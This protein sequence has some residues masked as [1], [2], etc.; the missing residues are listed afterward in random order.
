MT[1]SSFSQRQPPALLR[2]LSHKWTAAA[3]GHCPLTYS[4][5]QDLRSNLKAICPKDFLSSCTFSG[6][7]RRANDLFNVNLFYNDLF[8]RLVSTMT[9]TKIPQ[10]QQPTLLRRSFPPRTPVPR[11]NALFTCPHAAIPTTAPPPREGGEGFSQ[12]AP[13]RSRPSPGLHPGFMRLLRRIP[14]TDYSIRTHRPN[15]L[16]KLATQTIRTRTGYTLYLLASRACRGNSW[17]GPPPIPPAPLP[18]L[19]PPH[20]FLLPTLPLLRADS[21]PVQADTWS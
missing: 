1:N 21:S 2:R 5:P 11:I 17:P 7:P 14:R 8:E 15:T 6:L 13:A 9:S 12:G 20:S 3:H 18:L 16:S 19:P 4:T 10:Q